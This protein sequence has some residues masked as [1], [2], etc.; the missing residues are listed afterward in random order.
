MSPS[1]TVSEACNNVAPALT[2]GLAVA[3]EVAD[4]PDHISGLA[5][6]IRVP[7]TPGVEQIG[8]RC[9]QLGHWVRN[10]AHQ[11][12]RPIADLDKLL[13]SG[14]KL[15]NELLKLQKLVGDHRALVAVHHRP[16][17]EPDQEFIRA[18]DAEDAEGRDGRGQCDDE[19]PCNDSFFHHGL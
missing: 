11:T 3:D 4:G 10:R 14:L 6:E 2:K 8:G 19:R 13:L 16:Q 9:D 7:V 5:G 15:L 12:L 1:V 17:N 18:G